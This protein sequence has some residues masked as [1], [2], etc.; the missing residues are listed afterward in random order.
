MDANPAYPTTA[1]LDH[2]ARAEAIA[3]KAWRNNER[4]RDILRLA[5]DKIEAQCDLGGY[6][7]IPGM[8]LRDVLTTLDACKPDLHGDAANAALD[9]WAY[10]QAGDVS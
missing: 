8:D 5:R 2:E 3:M 10:E 1:A 7:L 6:S 9:A 4:L